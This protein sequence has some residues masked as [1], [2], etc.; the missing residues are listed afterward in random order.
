[1]IHI[2]NP[3]WLEAGWN[4]TYPLGCCSFGNWSCIHSSLI[5]SGLLTSLKIPDPERD[6]HFTQYF[7]SKGGSQM[8]PSIFFIGVW[9]NIESHLHVQ[10]IV[11]WN[12]IEYF[13]RFSDNPMADRD[14]SANACPCPCR[15]LSTQTNSCNKLGIPFWIQEIGESTHTCTSSNWRSINMFSFRQSWLIEVVPHKV[16]CGPCGYI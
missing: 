11:K 12:S 5:L 2:A 8:A 6:I 15:V 4:P 3:L 9:R 13:S 14:G 16:F 7:E 10:T 1:M